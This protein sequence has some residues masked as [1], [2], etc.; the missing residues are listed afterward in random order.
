MSIRRR[1]Q[2]AELASHQHKVGARSRKMTSNR[3]P[4]QGNYGE[5]LY[6]EGLK[7][8]QFREEQLG[9]VLEERERE[10]QEQ[11]FTPQISKMSKALKREMPVVER[12]LMLEQ[13]RA[14][15]HS[16]NYTLWLCFSF[17]QHV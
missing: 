13:V 5:F 2:A 9:Q 7:R 11:S 6:V 3:R 14:H 8:Q 1:E 15:W 4:E 16:N 10:G 17:V 12:L